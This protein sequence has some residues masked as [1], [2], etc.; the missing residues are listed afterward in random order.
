[1]NRQHLARLSA[2]FTLILVSSAVL[3][4]EPAKSVRRV[5]AETAAQAD[6]RR[7]L[8]R[9]LDIPKGDPAAVAPTPAGSVTIESLNT[10]LDAMGYDPKLGNYNDGSHYVTIA[11]PRSS[12]T[13]SVSFDLSP[14]KSNIWLSVY[15]ND[16]KDPDK[17]PTDTLLK[18]LE[19]ENGIWPTYISYN[20]SAKTLYAYRPL[21]NQDLKP[22]LMRTTIESYLSNVE[23]TAS[24]WDT[25]T[26]GQASAA[27]PAAK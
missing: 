7:S 18:L 6:M 22:A 21:K 20:T 24:L 10:M 17:A 14:D 16:V 3:A 11:V 26:W 5:G 8:Q 25:S 2:Y 15:L 27:A 1:M 19:V 12:Y 9:K 4:A 23:S 13:I